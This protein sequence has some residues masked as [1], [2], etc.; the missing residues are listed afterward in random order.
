MNG[1]VRAVFAVI[2][3]VLVCGL[4]TAHAYRQADDTGKGPV[5]IGSLLPDKAKAEE[6]AIRKAIDAFTAAYNGGDLDALMAV[7]AEDAEYIADTGKAIRGKEGVRVLLKKSLAANKGSKQSIKVQDV[8]FLKPDVA[9]ESGTVTLTAADGSASS[10]KYE[11]VWTKGG[12]KWLL[13]RVRDLTEASDDETPLA[14]SQ[15]KPLAWLVGEWEAKDG[16]GD[17]SLSCKWGP[18]QTFLGM[19]FVVKRPDVADLSISQRVGYDAATGAVRSWV[20]DSGGGFGGGFWER[21]GNTWTVGSEGTYPD[22]RP[23]ASQDGWKYV[24]D[25][26]FVWTAKDR[27]VDEAP[28]PDLSITFVKKKGR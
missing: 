23:A 25:D 1:R 5:I 21:E 18:G 22:G 26:E 3:A 19:E 27:Q 20:F 12:A 17:V 28:L 15:L 24:S 16:K 13:A 6:A 2:G 14:V 7:W 11:A 10:G 8:R 4:M 9:L